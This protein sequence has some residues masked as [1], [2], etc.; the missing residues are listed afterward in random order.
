LKDNQRV[1]TVD[2]VV[3][4]LA[5]ALQGEGL[6]MKKK[7]AVYSTAAAHGYLIRTKAF[8]K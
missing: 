1:I 3:E 5:L 6:S 7:N 4:C 2:T 8:R